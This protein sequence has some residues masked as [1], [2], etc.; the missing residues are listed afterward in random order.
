[1]WVESGNCDASSGA[2]LSVFDSMT[3]FQW[4]EIVPLAPESVVVDSQQ[5]DLLVVFAAKAKATHFATIVLIALGILMRILSNFCR[6]GNLVITLDRIKNFSSNKPQKGSFIF[7]KSL[8]DNW[9][10][11]LE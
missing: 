9:I 2:A 6:K 11:Q 4:L 1:M 5:R 10:F 3:S 7:L 8:L